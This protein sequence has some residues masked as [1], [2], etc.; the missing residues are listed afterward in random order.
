MAARPSVLTRT[1]FQLP[2]AL[3][4]VGAVAAGAFQLLGHSAGPTAA[5]STLPGVDQHPDGVVSVGDR[6]L[7]LTRGADGRLRCYALGADAAQIEPLAA[8]RLE[9]EVLREGTGIAIPIRLRAEPQPGDAPG[10]ASLFTGRLPTGLLRAAVQLHLTV[11]LK[12]RSYRARFDLHPDVGE[13]GDTAAMPQAAGTEQQQRLY[14]TPGGG[15][16]TADIAANGAAPPAEKYRGV[17]ASHHLHPAAG[18]RICPI[19]HTRANPRFA[20]TVGGKEYLFCCPPCIDEFVKLARTH[21][22]RIGAPERYVQ[23]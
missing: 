11:P 12:G 16:T 13:S 8:P 18:E 2:T 20:W 21:P 19:T 3:L 4:V 7:E 15:Y 6:H 23:R 5:S 14:A 9:G 10:T 22:T 1:L 17:P